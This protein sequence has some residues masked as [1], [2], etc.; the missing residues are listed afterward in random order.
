[1]IVQ[2]IMFGYAGGLVLPTEAGLLAMERYLNE[3]L[4]FVLVA[5]NMMI[6]ELRDTRSSSH[7]N[8]AIFD[9]WNEPSQSKSPS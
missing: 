3:A 1:M 2:G 5:V 7:V 6:V 8:D 9:D 4:S